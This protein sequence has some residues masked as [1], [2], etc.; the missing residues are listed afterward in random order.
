M[1]V[2][3]TSLTACV[4]FG[5]DAV[6]DPGVDAPT[7]DRSLVVVDTGDPTPGDHPAAV[8][9]GADAPS[10][11]VC[12][13]LLGCHPDKTCREL[14]PSNVSPVATTCGVLTLQAGSQINTTT[15]AVSGSS[16]PCAGSIQSLSG[17]A[18][19]CV[20]SMQ[21]LIIPKNVTVPAT[22]TPALILLVQQDVMVEGVLDAGAKGKNP[23]PGGAA[24]GQPPSST[25]PAPGGGPGGG[26]VCTCTA[27]YDIDDC[28]GG[29]GGFGSTGGAGGPE[30]SSCA[31]KSLGGVTYGVATLTPLLAG[32]GGA[33]GGNS[34]AGSDWPGPGGG[35]GG[36]VQISSQQTIRI[37][38]GINASGGGGTGGDDASSGAS[39][40]GG[41]GGS[42][43]AILLEAARIEGGGW[44]AVNGGGGGAASQ[45]PGVGS[46]GQDGQLG[47]VPAAGGAA[48]GQGAGGGNGAAGSG[49]GQ[50]GGAGAT[51]SGGGGGGGGG[52]GRIRLNWYQVH[53]GPTVQ[54]SGV[55]SMGAVQPQ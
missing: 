3:V 39:A 21:S 42:G 29:G 32:S 16:V 45:R 47:G 22:G 20:I 4:R 53:P 13:C 24:G 30:G 5:F 55:T 18:S 40:G 11:P 46:P 43:G 44:L 34:G 50:P 51:H 31:S 1:V 2:T 14:A 23:G 38:G 19:V 41:G 33:S 15:C 27:S 6:G 10:P 36:A 7:T 8:D 54:T 35:G 52:L 17:K 9:T 48:G 28:G 37:E 12:S 26:K 49:N 25:T